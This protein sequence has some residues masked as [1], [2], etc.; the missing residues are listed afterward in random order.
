MATELK[1]PTLG[2]DMEEA[3]IVR[4]LVE[5]GAEVEKGEP[6]LEID[7][8]KTS[9]EIEAPAGGIIRNLRGEEGETLPVGT[10]LAYVATPGEVLP[11]PEA[12]APDAPGAV[13][14]EEVETRRESAERRTAPDSEDGQK[15]RASP[16][17]RRAAA[18]MGVPIESVRGSGPY[19]RVYLSDIL[20]M[21]REPE[22]PPEPPL[23][24]ASPREPS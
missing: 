24:E 5:E 17:A 21:E 13:E 8:D 22:A 3:T 4:W 7:T 14:A 12:E 15:V 16:A 10:T 23:R 2:M 6:V 9:F 19:G 11:A 20:E 1:V 18:E